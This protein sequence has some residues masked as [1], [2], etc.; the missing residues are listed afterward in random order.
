MSIKPVLNVVGICRFPLKDISTPNAVVLLKQ[1]DARFREQSGDLPVNLLYTTEV[2]FNSDDLPGIIDGVRNAGVREVIVGTVTNT[3]RAE[4]AHR[5]GITKAVAP[6]FMLDVLQAAKEHNIDF[7]PGIAH[8]H[9][10]RKLGGIITENNLPVPKVLKLFPFSGEKTPAGLFSALKAPYASEIKAFE[11]GGGKIRLANDSEVSATYVCSPTDFANQLR[12]KAGQKQEI[13]IGKPFSGMDG[14]DTNN[15]MNIFDL[16]KRSQFDFCFKG[17]EHGAFGGV[18]LT[19]VGTLSKRGVKFIGL[20][21]DFLGGPILQAAN[22]GNFEPAISKVDAVIASVKAA[23][24][25]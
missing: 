10:K 16:L 7:I 3:D 13:V 14:S 17:T 15:A 11:A 18:K 1:I 12:V 6:D 4:T 2:S 19:D 20:G 22:E 8:Q 25:K 24:T 9:E 5:L 21:S 23:Y